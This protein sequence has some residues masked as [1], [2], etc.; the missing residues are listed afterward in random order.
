M[1]NAWRTLSVSAA[2]THSKYGLPRADTSA[3]A[4]SVTSV[5]SGRASALP[6]AE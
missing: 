1:L 6:V 4:C 2:A 5:T 3:I